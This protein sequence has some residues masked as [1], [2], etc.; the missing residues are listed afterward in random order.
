MK[1]AQMINKLPDG[2]AYYVLI[3][4]LSFWGGVSYYLNKVRNGAK[5]DTLGLIV[6][7]VI[8]AFVGLI[9][10]FFCAYLQLDNYLTAGLV[11]V[12]S[13]LGTRAIVLFEIWLMQRYGIQDKKCLECKL[14]EKEIN[15]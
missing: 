1:E 8:S 6:D 15:K 2:Y 12:S 3:L 5:F 10:F 11:G 13:H 14:H 7:T 9:T 4:I